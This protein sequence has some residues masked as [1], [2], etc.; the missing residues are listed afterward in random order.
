MHSLSWLASNG[1]AAIVCFP[2]IMYRGGAEQKI[3]KYLVDNN[4]IDCV[5]Q[6]PAN[7]FFGTSIATCIMVLKKGKTDNKVLFIDASG[8]FVTLTHSPEAS[9]DRKS[10]V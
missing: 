3:R 2:G 1:T 4:F 10:V 7:L 5:I 9:I 6:L 8:E